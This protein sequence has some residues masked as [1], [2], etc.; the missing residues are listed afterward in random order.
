M[1]AHVAALEARGLE[2]R[3]AASL[4]P[5]AEDGHLHADARGRNDMQ[6]RP[7]H[8]LAD[9]AFDAHRVFDGARHQHRGGKLNVIA[10]HLRELL[11]DE[12]LHPQGRDLELPVVLRLLFLE[13]S[14]DRFVLGV[15]ARGPE[16]LVSCPL[17]R[18]PAQAPLERLL[19]DLLLILAPG[20]IDR[21][22]ADLSGNAEVEVPRG[23]DRLRQVDIGASEF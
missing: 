2:V 10:I 16:G 3:A 4:E 23:G 8:G 9:Q 21:A 6:A 22:A 17:A 18:E 19:L 7:I 20:G 15:R 5:G 11:L 13:L 12:R 14:L 1:N